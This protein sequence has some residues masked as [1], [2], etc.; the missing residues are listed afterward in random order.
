VVPELV[1]V[2]GI[3]PRA[4]DHTGGQFVWTHNLA[5]ACGDM[6][7][8]KFGLRKLRRFIAAEIAAT[9]YLADKSSFQSAP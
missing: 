6:N 5:S 2:A 7:E 4:D 9:I 3:P 1:H 8:N